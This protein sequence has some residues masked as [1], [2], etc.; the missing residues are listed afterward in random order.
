MGRKFNIG[1]RGRIAEKK[2]TFKKDTPNWTEEVFEVVDIQNTNLV[3]YKVKD[4]NG[5]VMEG[6]FYE[7]ELQ[8]TSQDVFHIEV[9]RK[10]GRRALVKQKGYPDTF[11]S[12]VP[13]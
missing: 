3:T 9:I 12:W 11:N 1:D 5:E 2:T 4:W 7:P 13:M 8:K 10:E 6:S